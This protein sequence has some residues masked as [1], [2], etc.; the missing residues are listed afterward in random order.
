MERRRTRKASKTKLKN[1]TKFLLY[2]SASWIPSRKK[3]YCGTH[4]LYSQIPDFLLCL[5]CV[6]NALLTILY[7]KAKDKSMLY[8]TNYTRTIHELYTIHDQEEKKLQRPN[9]NYCKP[10]KKKKF[11]RLSIPPGLRGSND[12]RVGRKMAIFQLF[13][14]SRVGLRT[15]QHPCNL[16]YIAVHVV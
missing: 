8:V 12:L 5:F 14:F 13:F 1:S 2:S 7:L 11:R 4:E 9:S 15:Y 10:L 3:F 6:V 16:S